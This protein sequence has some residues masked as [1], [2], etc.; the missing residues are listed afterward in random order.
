MLLQDDCLSDVGKS[1]AP[2]WAFNTQL[3][4]WLAPALL[5]SPKKQTT[6]M[7]KPRSWQMQTDGF[8]PPWS[9]KCSCY[10]WFTPAASSALA[11]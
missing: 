10:C 2:C 1:W 9:W 4:I 6:R 3:C 5:P 7:S 8:N 11:V